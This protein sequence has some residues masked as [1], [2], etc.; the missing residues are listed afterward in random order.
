LTDF[1]KQVK[2]LSP[3]DKDDYARLFAEMGIDVKVDWR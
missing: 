1:A 2:A 3:A